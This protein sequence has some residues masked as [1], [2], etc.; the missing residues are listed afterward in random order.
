MNQATTRGGNFL[1]PVLAIEVKP[2]QG[3]YRYQARGRAFDLSVTEDP[4]DPNIVTGLPSSRKVEFRIDLIPGAM[5]VAKS[6]YRLEATEM[7][8]LSN[9][10][11]ELQDKG[12]IRPSSLPWGPLVLFVKKKDG[13]FRSRYFSK[14]DLL[15]GYHLLRVSKE[16]IP[17]TAFKTRFVIVFIDD[18]L[19]YSKSKEEHAV[20]LSLLRCIESRFWLCADAEKQG[21]ANVVADAL[22]RKER[23]KPRRARAMSITIHSSIKAR[24]LEML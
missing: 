23:V 15:Y 12:F 10:L 4:S 9:R 16:D 20:H 18:I 19:I 5:P 14:I 8:E 3:N 21:K 11:K 17:K 2:N 22:S 7:Q 6:P 24:I 13:S 1:N